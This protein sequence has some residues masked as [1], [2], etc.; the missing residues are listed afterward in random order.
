ML[1][2]SVAVLDI[3][4]SE[5]TS[6]VAE[7]GVNNTFIVK[8]KFAHAYEGYAEGQLLDIRSFETAVQSVVQ[9]TL[10]AVNEKIKTFYVSIP[11]EFSD[12]INSDNVISFPSSK[13]VSRSDVKNLEESS[14]PKD[15][16]IWRTVCDG[17]LFFVLSDK[18]KVINPIG[19]PTDS[20]RGRM[21]FYRCKQSFADCVTNAFHPF[22]GITHIVFVPSVHAQAMY[23]VAPERRDEYAVLFDFGYISSSFSV[24]CGNGVAYCESFSLGAGH[25]AVYLMEALEIPYDVAAAILDKVNLNA[26]EGSPATIEHYHEG[27]LYKFDA[28]T[29]RQKVAEG[30][31][32]ICEAIEECYANFTE[33][34]LDGKPVYITGEC[35]N[36][37]RGAT[38]HISNRLVRSVN[39]AAPNIPYYD[40]PQF[41]SL[42]SLIDYALN[43]KE[44]SSFFGSLFK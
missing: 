36:T 32:L 12:V 13:K 11:G 10:S 18:R 35:V 28:A 2:K 38:D 8:S 20:L 31:D 39:I 40:K 37:I 15:D 25:I 43:E 34:N 42:F 5:I 17:K 23:L 33:K 30:L 1:S 21:C 7:R 16:K 9:S 19:M 24:I 4:S 26:G 14:Y 22:A 27:K 3:R 29:L 44:S 41:S 6:V